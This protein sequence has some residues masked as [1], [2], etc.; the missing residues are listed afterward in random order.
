MIDTP[1]LSKKL[2]CTEK[3][4]NWL[5]YQDDGKR[6]RSY[7]ISKKNGS[8]RP[9]DEPI[10]ELKVIHNR[11]IKILDDSFRPNQAAHGF[12]KGRGI[13]TNAETHKRKRWVYNM[14]L[15]NFFQSITV[16]R[17]YGALSKWVF[18]KND[19]IVYLSAS[20]CSLLA[21]ICCFNSNKGRYVGLPQGASTSPII[22]NIICKNLDYQL[23]GYALSKKL[24][25]SRYADDI[26][27]SPLSELHANKIAFVC[28]A[29]EGVS[30]EV[31]S[32]IKNNGFKINYSKCRLNI[33]PRKLE[34]TGLVVNEIIN[35]PRKEVRYIRACLDL[36]DSRGFQCMQMKMKKKFTERHK[37]VLKVLVGKI[38]FLALVRGKGDPIYLKFRRKYLTLS[39]KENF[40]QKNVLNVEIDDFRKRHK[41]QMID[42]FKEFD[43]RFQEKDF[44]KLKRTQLGS[45]A[46]ERLEYL[47]GFENLIQG[48]NSDSI[49]PSLA[50]K[51]EVYYI[52]Y[53]H[54]FCSLE[55]AKDHFSIF[56]SKSKLSKELDW[57]LNYRNSLN[58][59]GG[60][61][62]TLEATNE[63][64]HYADYDCEVDEDE[65]YGYDS[66]ISPLGGVEV[67]A[68]ESPDGTGIYR[69]SRE[70]Y[71]QKFPDSPYPFDDDY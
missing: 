56:A 9:I 30:E 5:A 45:W 42:L 13:L 46:Y 6:F 59:E 15:E 37:N 67:D 43:R 35:I 36:W 68:N 71:Q 66:Y 31:T 48:I 44:L 47:K 70:E 22:S 27:F 52:L 53:L 21:N 51:A 49:V 64:S 10:P 26:T 69:L 4:L 63:N 61:N 57:W 7:S 62:N 29:N 23:A 40:E 34:V 25:F 41:D 50:I 11:I 65:D 12:L 33:R 32:I 55:I 16:Q 2:N 8:K 3:Q 1:E 17:V 58:G 39:A 18:Y 19:E 54:G 20:S 14:D 60:K 24:N 28:N 38:S